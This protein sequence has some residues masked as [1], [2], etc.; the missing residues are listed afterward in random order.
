M[1]YGFT[2]C[3]FLPVVLLWP[4]KL[5]TACGQPDAGAVRRLSIYDAFLPIPEDDR[6]QFLIFPQMDGAS[7]QIAFSF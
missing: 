7:V 5:P 1:P 6:F 3:K 4:V 2:P